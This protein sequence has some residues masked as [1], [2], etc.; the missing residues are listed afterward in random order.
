M[1]LL[2]PILL[3]SLL[4][5]TPVLFGLKSAAATGGQPWWKNAVIYEIYPR[6]FGDTNQ[7]GIG[8][9]N[10]ITEH[11]DYLKNLGIDAF[12]LTPIYPSPQVDF[13]YDI[14]NYEAVDPQYGTM[15]DFDRMMA[16]AKKRGLRIIM[17]MV[18]NHTSDQDPWFIESASSRTNPKASWYIWHDGKPNGQPPNNWQSI[19]G[20]SAWTYV[21]ARK[22]FYY[23]AFYKQQ[24]DLNWRNPA[25]RK[26]MYA[27]MKFWLDKGVAGFRLDAITSLFEDIALKDEPY[28]TGV[29]SYGDKNISRIYT[30]NLPEVHEVLRELHSV[31]EPYGAVLIGETYL[32]NAQELAK[33]YG[34]HN[35]EL[36][37][38]MD[39]QVG[40]I[41]KVSINDF[42]TKLNEAETMLNGNSPLIVFAN[43]DNP[44]A[45]NRYGDGK[46]N[47]AI[48]RM[49]ATILLAPRDTALIYYGQEL[50]M[51]DNPPKTIEDVRDPIGKLGWPKEKGR[52][53]E[54]T[55][56]QWNSGTD[57]GF[58]TASKT[59]LAINPDY[60]TV[61]VAT[62]ERDPNSLLN[63][64]KK[65]I[66]LRK[67]DAQL[68]DGEFVLVDP[69][70]EY[71]LSFLRKT[72]DGKAALVSINFTSAA[73]SPNLDLGSHGVQGQHL[74]TLLASF[75]NAQMPDVSHI[76]LPAFASFIAE[77]EP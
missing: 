45:L 19:F 33:M 8:D 51:T 42:R 58:S 20:H 16:E 21:P 6:S 3:S 10:G 75:P 73:H 18:L 59:W 12:W 62:E 27:Q 54:R 31:V 7:D 46:H 38:P 49:I 50:G 69:N 68:R 52:D 71:V 53:E 36:Q 2:R 40:F 22:Q 26:A 47:P 25:V 44:R 28:L 1:R 67:E 17:D 30:D 57:A 65:L 9:L 76:K 60:K 14:S 74:K 32:P 64:Y 43:H 77:I 4:L 34:K 23:H 66:R 41:N 48:A 29:N 37:L 15:A 24:P 63:F 35:D 11:L 56:M 72:S 70:D 61:N 55:P 13:G 39:T 5:L